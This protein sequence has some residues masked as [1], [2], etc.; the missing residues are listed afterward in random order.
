[1]VTSRRPREYVSIQRP[2]SRNCAGVARSTA[3]LFALNSWNPA[4]YGFSIANEE[5]SMR[6]RARLIIP[7]WGAVYAEKLVSMTISALLT[8]G[9]L[10][11]LCTIFDV[12]VVLVTESNLFDSIHQATSFQVLSTS[13]RTKLQ[14]WTSVSLLVFVIMIDGVGSGLRRKQTQEYLPFLVS[15]HPAD[16]RR[17]RHG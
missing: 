3:I 8:P 7:L 12:E 11:A 13:C 6:E 4:R 10:P 9:N 17:H 5:T 2:A 1:M 15:G 14:F 16:G